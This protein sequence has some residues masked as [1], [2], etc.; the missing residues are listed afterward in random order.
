MSTHPKTPQALLQSAPHLK[1]AA[2]WL[3]VARLHR[4]GLGETEIGKLVGLS[5]AR[6]ESILNLPRSELVKA[7]KDCGQ[8]WP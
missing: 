3:E 8:V 5:E 2:R 4:T 7:A 1:A 6:V